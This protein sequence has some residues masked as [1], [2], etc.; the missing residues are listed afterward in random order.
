MQASCL[1]FDAVAGLRSRLHFTFYRAGVSLY[2]NNI[3]RHY[4]LVS[5]TRSDLSVK[6]LSSL[7]MRR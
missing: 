1:N 6:K 5:D 7:R 3:H 4:V 2:F